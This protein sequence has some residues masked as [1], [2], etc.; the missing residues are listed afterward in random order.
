[1]TT[2]DNDTYIPLELIRLEAMRLGTACGMHQGL[3]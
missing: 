1:M 3:F 2:Y